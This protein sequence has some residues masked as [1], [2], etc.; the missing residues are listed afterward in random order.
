M[1]I[2]PGALGILLVVDGFELLEAFG[3][4][5]IIVLGEGDERERRRSVGIRHFKWRTG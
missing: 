1:R 5:V 3:L 2:V 4:Q